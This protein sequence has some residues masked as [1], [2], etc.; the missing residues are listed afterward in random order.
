MCCRRKGE[1]YKICFNLTFVDACFLVNSSIFYLCFHQAVTVGAVCQF[2]DE[3][4]ASKR[5]KTDPE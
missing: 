2:I 5:P 1:K 3:A 4:Q